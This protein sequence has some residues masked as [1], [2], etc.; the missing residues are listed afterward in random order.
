M[1]L[2]VVAKADAK[3]VNDVV[4]RLVTLSREDLRATGV[5]VSLSTNA[6]PVT[7]S[8]KALLGTLRFEDLRSREILRFDPS[9]VRRLVRTLPGR[10]VQTLVAHRETRTWRVEGGDDKSVVDTEALAGVLAELNP[11]KAARIERLKVAANELAVYG[12]E[13]PS[14]VIAVDPEAAGAIR[15]NL[16]I[17]EAT[18]GGRFATV[19]ASEAVFV[20]SN[21]TLA[22][23]SAACI[24]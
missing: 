11:L 12:L 18:A 16:L 6:E 13:K 7:V 9:S 24:E 15:R 22:R 8:R 2:P 23:L 20:I 1:E 17:G 10:P 3:L 19:G 4:E 14:F 21:E 5:L